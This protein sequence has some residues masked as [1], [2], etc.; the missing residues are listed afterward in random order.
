MNKKKNTYHAINV[1]KIT[2]ITGTNQ[3]LCSRA[4]VVMNSDVV[5][6]W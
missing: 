3:L 1:I 2:K 6:S 4:G 5:Y